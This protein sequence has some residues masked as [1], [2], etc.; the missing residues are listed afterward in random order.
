MSLEMDNGPW[1]FHLWV[2]GSDT[3]WVGGRHKVQLIASWCLL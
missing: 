3:A 1:D 2:T